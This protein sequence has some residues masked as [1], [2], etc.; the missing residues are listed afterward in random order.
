LVAIITTASK[1]QLKLLRAERA[2]NDERAI[3]PEVEA[4]F[5]GKDRPGGPL[6]PGR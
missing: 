3:S 1:K 4:S 5:A 6:P 2:A